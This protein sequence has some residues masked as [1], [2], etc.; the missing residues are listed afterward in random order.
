MLNIAK[1]I[2]KKS[3]IEKG[4]KM[5]ELLNGVEEIIT[6]A[7]PKGRTYLSPKERNGYADQLLSTDNLGDSI[8]GEFAGYS[9]NSPYSEVYL[10]YVMTPMY[11]D[12]F[13][14]TFKG[15]EGFTSFSGEIYRIC[16]L[17]KQDKMRHVRSIDIQ[18][19]PVGNIGIDESYWVNHIEIVNSYSPDEYTYQVGY[20]EY[21]R[22]YSTILHSKKP[23]SE[24]SWDREFYGVRPVIYLPLPDSVSN[25]DAM[26]LASESFILGK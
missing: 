21:E 5:S 10:K 6:V 25:N 7:I 18:D 12:N 20:V 9:I 17:I 11:S 23:N 26:E 8:I 19:F 15:L 24:M 2:V 22:L 4:N 14:I 13:G 3:A 1:A 16:Q